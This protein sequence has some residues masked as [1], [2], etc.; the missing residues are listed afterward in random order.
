MTPDA[1]RAATLLAL[2]FALAAGAVPARAAEESE[3][4]ECS[5]PDAPD[6]PGGNGVPRWSTEV[7]VI[8]ERAPELRSRVP[9]A[10]SVMDREQIARQPALS[11]SELLDALPGFAVFSD[12]GTSG[13]PVATARGFFGGA[14]S[15]YVQLRIDGVPVADVESSL[16]DWRAVP[17]ADLERIEV[18]RGTASSL[19]GDTA[20]GGVVEVT[21]RGAGDPSGTVALHAGSLG[22]GGLDAGLRRALGAVDLSLRLSGSRSDGAREHAGRDELAGGLG[23]GYGSDGRRLTL[24]LAFT[25]RDRDDPGPLSG[26]ELAADRRGSNPAFRFDREQKSAFRGALRYAQSWRRTRLQAAAHASTRSSDLVRTLWLAP[27]FPDSAARTLDTGA[28]GLLLDVERRYALGG[29]TGELRGGAELSREDLETGYFAVAPGGAFGAP[30]TDAAATR[31][32]QAAFASLGWDA[33]PRLRLTAGLRWDRIDDTRDGAGGEESHQAWSP[34]AG[35]N[36]RLGDEPFPWSLFFQF[37]RSFKAATL[38]QLFDP[39][40][41]PDFQGGSITISNP[42]LRP[43][44]ARSFEIGVSHRS[45]GARWQLVGYRIDADDEIDFDVATFSYAN[46]VES[47]HDGLEAELELW[48]GRR[49]RPSVAYTWSRTEATRGPSRGHQLKNVP[50]HVLQPALSLDLP[51]GLRAEVRLRLL[52]GTYLDDENAFPVPDSTLLDLRLSGSAGRFGFS[53]DAL[54]VTDDERAE[55]GF[56]LADFSGGVVPYYY[57][58]ARFALRLRVEARF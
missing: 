17:V 57:P 9:A 42:D 29:T 53:L 36:L 40:P 4:P 38:D 25:D 43:Q 3:P 54:N 50:E 51:A 21:T 7:V 30:A 49:V 2:T 19:Y 33:T 14:E 23:V 22:E 20:L 45:A 47:R 12:E 41:F 1:S 37:S 8:A 10:T 28:V 44:R 48:P 27:G 31:D 55:Y 24:D 56:T 32:R 13:V 52:S 34:R 6:C 39:R 16:A 58:G 5:E 11:L 15:G 46:I 26:D 18:L 35:V